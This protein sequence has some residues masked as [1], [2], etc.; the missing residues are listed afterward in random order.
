MLFFTQ[1]QETVKPESSK[2]VVRLDVKLVVQDA[3]GQVNVTDLM[4]QGGE[5]AT[6]WVGHASEI[7]WSFDG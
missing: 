5:I 3:V 2:K 6:V 4:L 7:K 1:D